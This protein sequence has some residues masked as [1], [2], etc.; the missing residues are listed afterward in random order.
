MSE[1][2]YEIGGK[3]SFQFSQQ[4]NPVQSSL[5]L[6]DSDVQHSNTRIQVRYEDDSN[7]SFVRAQKNYGFVRATLYLRDAS[8][9]AVEL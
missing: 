4:A 9:C 5:K 2:K 8:K 1:F 7:P 3:K 6:F